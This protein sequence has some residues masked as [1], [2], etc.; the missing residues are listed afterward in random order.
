MDVMDVTY[1]EDEAYI[2]LGRGKVAS[3]KEVAPGVVIDLGEDGEAIGL[4]VLGLRRRGLRAGQVG[5]SVAARKAGHEVDERRLA[6]LMA[7]EASQAS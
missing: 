1:G 6:E 4:E 3:S 5:V 2:R 7:G